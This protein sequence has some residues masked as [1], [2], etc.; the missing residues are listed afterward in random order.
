MS[1]GIGSDQAARLRALV[2]DMQDGAQPSSSAPSAE[3][4]RPHRPVP[5][6]P[7]HALPRQTA[8][9][10]RARILA[11]ASGKGGVGKTTLAV[12]L[13]AAISEMGKRVTLIDG[14]LGLAN[15][16][17]LCGVR[18][19]RNIGDVLDGRCALHDAIADTPYGFRVLPG[20]SGLA[21]LAA[22]GE[23]EARVIVG[24]FAAMDTMS[25]IVLIDCGAGIGNIVH[26]FMLA[27]DRSLIVTTPDPMAV[28]DAYAL[29]KSLASRRCPTTGGRPGF[30]LV[31]NQAF[32]DEE[33]HSVCCRV[34]A[35]TKKFLGIEL[36]GGC[37]VLEDDQI[38]AE[39]RHC[40]PFVVSAPRSDATGCVRRVA[41]SVLRE[42]EMLPESPEGVGA[43]GRFASI[44]RLI[45]GAGKGAKIAETVA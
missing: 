17:L 6:A 4:A 8:R 13:A 27:A 7:T 40:R 5:L 14:D 29:I 44:L 43:M 19:T 41:Q 35:V 1:A 15:A 24:R 16:D 31:V 12:N 21:R 11:I 37:W 26:A 36:A 3:L 18:A 30:S 22:L 9:Q 45:T 23:R 38:R 33:A 34:S 25:D 2:R 32:D 20:A 10:S 39:G 28:T 42:F